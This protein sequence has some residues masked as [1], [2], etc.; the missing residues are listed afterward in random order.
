MVIKLMPIKILPIVLAN[1]AKFSEDKKENNIIG[2][3]TNNQ[4]KNLLIPK[5]SI[6]P[7]FK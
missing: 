2:N 1:L 6:K 3:E 4:D 5:S 7:L